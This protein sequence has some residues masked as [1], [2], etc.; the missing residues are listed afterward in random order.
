MND[1]VL[2]FYHRARGNVTEEGKPTTCLGRGQAYDLLRK[3]ASL[4][5]A[6]R[7]GAVGEQVEGA[8]PGCAGHRGMR[9][10]APVTAGWRGGE[11]S[12]VVNNWA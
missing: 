2:L 11:R 1:V 8:F 10:S 6:Q 7:A 4:R 9:Q 5:L 12:P 3:R